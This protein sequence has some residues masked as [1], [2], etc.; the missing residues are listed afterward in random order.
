MENS[1]ETSPSR[2]V[3]FFSAVERWGQR[4][5]DPLTLF[6]IMAALVVL[7]SALFQGLSAQ[8]VQRTGDVVDLS[9]QSLLTLEG[10]PQH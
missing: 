3:R 4:L 5:P 1:P 6:A 2:L 7:M 8:V 9:V 10:I